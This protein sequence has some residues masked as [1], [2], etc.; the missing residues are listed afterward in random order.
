MT[1][2]NRSLFGI[3]DSAE[4]HDRLLRVLAGL[5]IEGTV[6]PPSLGADVNNYNPT[7]HTECGVLRLTAS[8]SVNITGLQSLQSGRLLAIVNI[9]SN[10]ITLKNG[11]ASSF[12]NNRFTLNADIVLQAGAVAIVYYDTNTWR[13]CANAGIVLSG[14]AGGDLTGTYPNPTIASSAVT[15]AKLANMAANSIKGNNTGGSAVV[16]DLTT[17]PTPCMPALTGDVTNTAGTLGTTVGKI[18]GISVGAPTGTAGSAVV[19]ATSPTLVTPALGTPSGGVL[20]NCTGLPKAGLT[21]QAR[22]HWNVLINGGCEVVQRPVLSGTSI[23]TGTD[24]YFTDRWKIAAC[25]TSTVTTAQVDTNGSLESGL[26]ARYY[27]KITKSTT[28]AKLMAYQWVEAS[29]TFPLAGRT[30]T[31]QLKLKATLSAGDKKFRI[32]FVSSTGTV[33]APGAG[34]ETAEGAAGTDPTLTAANNFAYAATSIAVP[35]GANGAVNGNAVDCTTTTAWQLFAVSITMPAN[36]KNIAVAIWPNTAMTATDT[37]SISECQLVDG[38]SIV[39]YIPR[40]FQQ[41]LALCQRYCYVTNGTIAS[42]CFGQ[43]L[44]ISVTALTPTIFLP[45][46]MRISP[47]I[48]FSGTIGH[49][50]IG[51]ASSSSAVTTNPPVAVSFNAAAPFNTVTPNFTASG[52]TGVLT[53]TPGLVYWNGSATSADM[54]IFNADF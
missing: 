50:T 6:S 30:V 12:V 45:V 32:G 44:F 23:T 10:N 40:P 52:L 34:F 27:H 49:L 25:T 54:L 15:N 29:N 26:N 51:N 21:S 11:S 3:P 1:P 17:L 43:G 33:D 8:T 38:G 9:G 22:D 47:V 18:Q 39:D 5:T 4:A 53:S 48:S 20:T 7:N 35:T 42:A 31:F 16:T 2:A 46:Q 36:A 13:C 41:E 28:T 24:V 37:F 19:L 14:P